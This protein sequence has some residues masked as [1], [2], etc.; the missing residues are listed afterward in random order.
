MRYV[1]YGGLEAVYYGD[2]D[3]YRCF[4]VRFCYQ[5]NVTI[6]LKQNSRSVIV[7]G[8]DEKPLKLNPVY[9][10][11][12]SEESRSKSAG[13]PPKTKKHTIPEL[14]ASGFLIPGRFDETGWYNYGK[15]IHLR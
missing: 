4:K 7:K 11:N 6:F 10:S 1:G 8:R 9:N 2:Q 12:P 14:F 15:T 5:T 13:G 3:G